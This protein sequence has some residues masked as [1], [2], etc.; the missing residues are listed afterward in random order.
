MVFVVGSHRF[1]LFQCQGMAGGWPQ[2][3][4]SA[5]DPR[6][7]ELLFL[8]MGLSPSLEEDGLQ[9]SLG[10]EPHLPRTERRW[11]MLIPPSGICCLHSAGP[12][13]PPASALKSSLLDVNHLGPD[14]QAPCFGHIYLLLPLA[15]DG[16]S[17]VGWLLWK[18]PFLL[19][20]L[21]TCGILSAI[22]WACP[23]TRGGTMW[24]AEGVRGAV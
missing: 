20:S 9:P 18:G 6:L 16:R 7:G 10:N 17:V 14:H 8:E 19:V 11:G 21:L 23:S 12:H 24:A 2:S 5:P 15:P 13:F 1:L 22:F 4:F 3:L